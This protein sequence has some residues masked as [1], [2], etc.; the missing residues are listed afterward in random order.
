[1]STQ[2]KAGHQELRAQARRAGFIPLVTEYKVLMQSDLP[3]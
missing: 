1:M 3:E 2:A